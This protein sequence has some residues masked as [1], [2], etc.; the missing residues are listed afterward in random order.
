[1]VTLPDRFELLYGN[2]RKSAAFAGATVFVLASH[3]N[4]EA[5]CAIGGLPTRR[6]AN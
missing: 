3:S 5:S 1:M 4:C 6:P 2:V